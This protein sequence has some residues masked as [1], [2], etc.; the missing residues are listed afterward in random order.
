MY[1]QTL[2]LV[3]DQTSLHALRASDDLH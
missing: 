1:Q 2:I 3:T